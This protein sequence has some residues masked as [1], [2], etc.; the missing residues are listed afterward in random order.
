MAIALSWA[1]NSFAAD[2]FAVSAAYHWPICE[3]Y[4]WSGAPATYPG[5]IVKFTIANNAVTRCDTLYHGVAESPVINIAGTRI[6]F[7]AMGLQIRQSGGGWG[8]VAGT[9]SRP[10]TLVVIDAT[11]GNTIARLGGLNSKLYCGGTGNDVSCM[12]WPAGDWVYYEKPCKTG[13]IWRFNIITNQ[14]EQLASLGGIRR[15]T[16]SVKGDRAASQYGP[17]PSDPNCVYTFPGLQRVGIPRPG[18]NAALSASGLYMADYEGSHDVTHLIKYDAN[19]SSTTDAGLIGLSMVTQWTGHQFLCGAGSA[20]CPAGELM[21]W[22][23]NSDKWY[24]SQ[25]GVCFIADGIHD[26]SNQ[27]LTNWVDH[28]GIITTDNPVLS[29]CLPG[30]IPSFTKC[31]CPGDFWIRPPSGVS[32]GYEDVAGAWRDCNTNAIIIPTEVTSSGRRFAPGM[33]IQ[34]FRQIL[35]ISG[36]APVELSIVDTRGR[37]V[38]RTIANERISLHSL[39]LRA[40]SYTLHYSSEGNIMNMPIAAW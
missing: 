22:A 7:F 18:C 38:A 19:G 31:N 34:D 29:S 21:R 15:W 5:K 17:C 26:G 23:A 13:Q 24:C 35:R 27:L 33:S 37:I 2:G 12:D 25:I 6:A 3:E 4:R 16:I 8:L 1:I 20:Q 30:N 36:N 32:N 10:C 9:A 14:N 28:Q 39:G 40:G 11:N